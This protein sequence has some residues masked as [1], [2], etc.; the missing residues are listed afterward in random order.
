MGMRRQ[1]IRR[2]QGMT[3]GC[4]FSDA[5]GHTLIETVV[6]LAL[7]TVVLIPAGGTLAHL[8]ID[9]WAGRKAEALRRAE[10]TMERTLAD[11]QLR[12]EVSQI[13][14]GPWR[15]VRDVWRDDALW[16]IRVGVYWRDQAGPT[17]TLRTARAAAAV[18]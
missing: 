11:G 2:A 15:I 3:G 14:E 10:R 8:M 17:V 16:K 13:H 9:D 7:L 5:E 18:P 6:A 12:S 1:I 4:S